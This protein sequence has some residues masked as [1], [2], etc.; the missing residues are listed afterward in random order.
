MRVCAYCGD[1]I[2]GT[3]S[4]V[5]SDGKTYHP[6]CVECKACEEQVL[7]DAQR[8]VSALGMALIIAVIPGLLAFAWI[9]VFIAIRGC[10]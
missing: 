1:E 5:T 2:K 4:T 9:V 8:S 3:E 6:D 7:I 10:K